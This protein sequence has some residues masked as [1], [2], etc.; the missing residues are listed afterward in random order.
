MKKHKSSDKKMTVEEFDKIYYMQM[1]KQE[2]IQAKINYQRKEKFI[3]KELEVRDIQ[4]KFHNKIMSEDQA[5]AVT[6]KFEGYN[7]EREM[8]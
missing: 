5:W 4:E 8:R 2:Q 3:Q 6:Q 1:K 7:K